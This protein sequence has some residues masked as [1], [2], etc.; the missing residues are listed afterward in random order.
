MMANII[1]KVPDKKQV[2]TWEV[3]MVAL[4]REKQHAAGVLANTVTLT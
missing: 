1:N 2:Y 4:A 3:S